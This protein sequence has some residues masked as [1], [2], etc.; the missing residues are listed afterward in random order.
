MRLNELKEVFRKTGGHCHFCGDR[1]VFDKR[2]WVAKP[3][4]HW[5]AD[6][7]VQRGKG[8]AKAAENCLPACTVCNR[9]RWHRTGDAMRELLLLGLI[10][11]KEMKNRTAAGKEIRKLVK[12]RWTENA[13]RRGGS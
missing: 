3:A 2:G 8:G 4:G 12:R 13:R 7:V 9:L 6:H 5:E 10:A 11:K 1:L